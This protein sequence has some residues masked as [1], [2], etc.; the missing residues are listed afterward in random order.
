MGEKN[1]LYFTVHLQGEL[2]YLSGE[3]NCFNRV[4]QKP[5]ASLPFNNLDGLII[6]DNA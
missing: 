2:L 1:S 4:P 6:H 5:P 3:P